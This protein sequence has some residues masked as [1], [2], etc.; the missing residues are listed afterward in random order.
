[1]RLLLS[2]LLGFLFRL[3][4]FFILCRLPALW[5]SGRKK[6]AIW[7]LPYGRCLD[8]SVARAL[9]KSTEAIG[10]KA[11]DWGIAPSGWTHGKADIRLGAGAK[12]T[13]SHLR[14][15][16]DLSALTR[17]WVCATKKI[18]ATNAGI[19]QHAPHLREVRDMGAATCRWR[20]RRDS[21]ARPFA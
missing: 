16:H 18:P 2:Y 11:K 9:T 5:E 7:I 19:K 8:E 12:E 14:E 17:R 3:S 1:M 15:M 13:A 4:Y 20:P 10:E 6:L 21:N